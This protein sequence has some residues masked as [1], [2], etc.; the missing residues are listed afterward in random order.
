MLA[1]S[2]ELLGQ[3][4][5]AR[6]LISCRFGKGESLEAAGLVVAWIIAYTKPASGY[7]GPGDVNTTGESG[8]DRGIIDGN[9]G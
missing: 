4:A 3:A 6:C 1:V 7:Q 8:K 2:V 9:G 5:D